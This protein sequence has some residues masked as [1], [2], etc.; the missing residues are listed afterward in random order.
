MPEASNRH[1]RESLLLPGLSTLWVLVSAWPAFKY[2][3]FGEA[4]TY[5]RIYELNDRHL[6]LAAFSSQDGQFF[7]PGYFLSGMFWHAVL[8]PDAMVYHIRNFILCAIDFFLFYRVLLKFVRSQRAR[9]VALGLLAGSKI[10]L[11]VIGYIALYEASVLLMTIL[12]SVLF[13]FRYLEN[14]R[15][16][17]YLLTLFFCTISAYSKDN[18]FVVIGVLAAMILAIAY[19]PG[20]WMSQA[21]YWSLR[22]APFVIISLS[23]LA[24]RYLLTGPINPNNE[25]YSP[26]LSLPVTMWQ[27][28]AF[29][30]T[31]GN[32]TLTN[33]DFMGARGFTGLLARD[34]R[35]VEYLL[36]GALWLLIG[37]TIW[38]ARSSWRL[39]IV[40]VVWIGL[41]LSPIFLI[42][43]HQVYYH[44]EPLAGLALLLG[45]CLDHVRRRLVTTWLAVVAL[46]T[47][48]GFISNRRSLY[49]WEWVADKTAAVVKPIV[50]SERSN[51]PKTI[52][53]VSAP[54]VRG[55]WTYALG[56]PLVPQLLRSPDS[57]VLIVE[58]AGLAPADAHVY[59]LPEQF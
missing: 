38:K 57:R 21:R 25:I 43:N 59:Y 33:P 34:S 27:A 52:V 49:T 56:G 36:C 14:R 19:K 7:R 48:N 28:K 16:S 4:F 45:I 5:L 12:L 11:T 55:F 31:A 18:G 40:P 23:Y 2:Y 22:F 1:I 9:I 44:Q 15:T 29:F 42:R 13:W 8:P 53:F 37:F 46:I 24:L 17:D 30:A 50:E 47:V 35:L 51:P 20:E 10:Y 32:L 41:Y 54:K 26:R 3:F 39:L 58:S 6:W